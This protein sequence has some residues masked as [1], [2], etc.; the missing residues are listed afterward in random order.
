MSQRPSPSTS[1][2]ATPEPFC[3]T[4]FCAA[5]ASESK[6]VKRIP[7]CSGAKRVKPLW[8]RAGTR[9]SA[10]RY[11]TACSQVNVSSARSEMQ[12]KVA[13]KNA[14]LFLTMKLQ[15]SSDLRTQTTTINLPYQSSKVSG[16]LSR[17]SSAA[18]LPAGRLRLLDG[19]LRSR[20]K[21]SHR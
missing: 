18:H 21:K 6:L 7:V 19:N 17:K 15:K 8:P 12:T 1:P 10:H 9:K 5:S 2:R 20:L 13:Q 14:T 16:T 11:P 4:R 3:K